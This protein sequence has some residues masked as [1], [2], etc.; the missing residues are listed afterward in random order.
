MMIKYKI[1]RSE[2][3]S[4]PGIRLQD[5]RREWRWYMHSMQHALGVGS[6]DCGVPTQCGACCLSLARPRQRGHLLK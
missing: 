4:R 1:N 2:H 3:A 5:S 6:V